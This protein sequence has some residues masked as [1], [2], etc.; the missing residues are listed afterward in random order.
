MPPADSEPPTLPPSKAFDEI[1]NGH[2]VINEKVEV[3]KVSDTMC[4]K[5]ESGLEDLLLGSKMSPTFDVF[6]TLGK[7]LQ[8]GSYGTVFMGVHN[9]SEREYAIKVVDR[10][11]L[12]R[13]DDEAQMQ[14]VEILRSLSPATFGKPKCSKN[15]GEETED[16]GIINLIDFYHSPAKYHIVMELARG[17]DVFDRLAKRKVYTEKHARDLARRMLE[18]IRYLH[19]RGIAHRDIKPENL[20]FESNEENSSIKLIDFGLSRTHGI[21]DR[22]MINQVGT[23]YYMS[24]GVLKGKYDRSCDL[25]AVGIVSYIVLSGYPPFN[26]SSDYEVEES[27]LRGNLVF[28]RD[29]W[30]NLSAASRDFVSKLLCIDSSKTLSAAEALQHPWIV[31]A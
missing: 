4:D 7:K 17:G 24:P 20:L 27:I 11:K 16:N 25:W 9:L 18:S 29:V 14:E 6:Y 31:S 22:A 30:G 5:L 19:E 26:G 12:S 2:V 13:N 8:G 1:S 15:H 23:S 21:N 3:D 28:E 10:T